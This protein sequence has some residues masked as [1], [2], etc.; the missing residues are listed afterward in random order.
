VPEKATF[1][2]QEPMPLAL[3]CASRI[4]DVDAVVAEA[5]Q[6]GRAV[7]VKVAG[8][9]NVSG[10]SPAARPEGHGA[11]QQGGFGEGVAS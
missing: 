10:R 7:S 6:V 2:S 9:A 4:D 3:N 8:D 5:D 1:A 11:R